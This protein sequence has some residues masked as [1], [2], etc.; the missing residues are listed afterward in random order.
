MFAFAASAAYARQPDTGFLNRS[1]TVNGAT[2]HYQV[3]VPAGWNRHQK[4][5]VLLALHGYG[6]RGSDGL[7]STDIGI[8]HAIR[9]HADRF[10]L[11]VVIPQCPADRVWTSKGMEDVAIAT[12]DQTVHEFKGDR[13]RLYLTG[14]SMGGYATWDM[15]VRYPGK[16]AAFAPVCGGLQPAKHIPEMRSS[17]IDDPKVSDPYAETAKR[18][19]QTPIWVFHGADDPAVP[20]EESRKMAA[21]LQAGGANFK[22]T[23]YPGVGHN[24]WDNAYSEPEFVPWLLAQRRR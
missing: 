7:L 24:S 8:G 16:F 6:E 15:T 17:L 22:Y 13:E 21:A 9:T 12:L 23:E 19:G 18:I 3:Y 14:L 5:P 20:V 2:Y 1:V 10:N 4:W 11:L